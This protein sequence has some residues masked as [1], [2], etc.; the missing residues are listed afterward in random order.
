[1]LYP[2]LEAEALDAR[3]TLNRLSSSL[4]LDVE[5]KPTVEHAETLAREVLTLRIHQT[6]P[7]GF[8]ERDRERRIRKVHETWKEYVRRDEYDR[9]IA[10]CL[11]NFE[12]LK[13]DRPFPNRHRHPNLPVSFATPVGATMGWQ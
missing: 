1:M 5:A 9:E 3:W 12:E 13:G 11:R 2:A 4:D 7:I 6:L 10:L 8:D